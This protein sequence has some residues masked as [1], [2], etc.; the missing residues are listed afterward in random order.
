[1]QK[2][3]KGFTLVELL[4]VIAILAILAA[5]SVVGYLSFTEKAKESNDISL[6]TQMNTILQGE[7][8]TDGVN[9][10]THDAVLDLKDN[11]LDVTK[12]TPTRKGY[13]FVYD[14]S[15]DKF[16]LL[17]QEK[18]I[19]PTNSSLSA[20]KTDIYKFIGKD[21]KLSNEYSNYL[22]DDYLAK[23]TL[24]TTSGI[25]VGNNETITNIKYKNTGA[26]KKAIIRTNGGTLTI[27]APLDTIYH[28]GESTIVRVNAIGENSYHEM[29]IVSSLNVKVGRIVVEE[30]AAVSEVFIE[31]DANIEGLKVEIKSSNNKLTIVDSTNKA[32]NVVE[33]NNVSLVTPTYVSNVSELDAAL[34][35]NEKEYVVLSNDI[36]TNENGATGDICTTSNITINGNGH[37]IYGH[38]KDKTTGYSRYATLTF[39]AKT[40]KDYK[41][42]LKN[43]TIENDSN[44]ECVAIA[45]N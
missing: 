11:G 15:Q 9:K 29:G 36:Y 32:A 13:E 16:F 39:Y 8:A 26:K 21:G 28:Y 10:T 18:V 42:I 34:W 44:E 7:S 2:K 33:G 19:A 27:E 35:T 1:M 5:V 12:L 6:I 37:K 22:K 20:Y 23:E 24:T 38:R 4:V 3:K 14:L 30:N 25:D 17:D 41:V 31:K 45:V 43:L 40:E